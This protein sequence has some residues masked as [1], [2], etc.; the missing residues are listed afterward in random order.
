MGK[1]WATLA[2]ETAI[3]LAAGAGVRMW[4]YNEVRNKCALPVGGIP[5]A[6]LLVEALAEADV[7]RIV[8][9][10]GAH[11]GS[12]RAA[13]LGVQLPVAYAEQSRPSGTAVTSSLPRLVWR[14]WKLSA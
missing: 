3:I 12:V 6:R 14:T 4:P 13:L 11:A 2:A 9:V 7:R 1:E 10:V 8:V 5:N